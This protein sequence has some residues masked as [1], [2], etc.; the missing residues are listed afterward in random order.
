MGGSVTL[1]TEP[2][3]RVTARPYYTVS[4]SEEGFERIMQAPELVVA[5]PIAGPRS[6]FVISIE[7]A[8]F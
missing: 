6:V 5:W 8:K 2:P 7:T 3:A 4:Q 1:R